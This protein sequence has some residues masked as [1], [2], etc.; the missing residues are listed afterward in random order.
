MPSLFES[1]GEATHRAFWRK[2][3]IGSAEVVEITPPQTLGPM[4][5]GPFATLQLPEPVIQGLKQQ[6]VLKADH[7]NLCCE[8]PDLVLNQR[9]E[10]IMETPIPLLNLATRMATGIPTRVLA[11][12]LEAETQRRNLYNDPSLRICL[13][14]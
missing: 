7:T 6:G 5:M 3:S 9:V 4:T 11:R 2:K 10:L 12:P 1:I 8:G 14:E 13:P